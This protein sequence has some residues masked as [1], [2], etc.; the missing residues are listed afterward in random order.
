MVLAV[1]ELKNYKFNSS[2][3]DFEG[4][5]G[6]LARRIFHRN[7]R[8][9]WYNRGVVYKKLGKVDAACK[10]FEKSKSLGGKYEES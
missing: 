4:L 7:R 9:K 8:K 3:E 1:M 6:I 5:R 10:S 2:L